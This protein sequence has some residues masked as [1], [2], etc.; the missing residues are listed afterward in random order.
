MEKDTE[1]RPEEADVTAST[2]LDQRRTELSSGDLIALGRATA[3]IGDNKKVCNDHGEAFVI[4]TTPEGGTQL[5]KIP[6]DR[7]PAEVAGSAR[8]QDIAGFC[9]Y[10]GRFKGPGSYIFRSE[11]G[12]YTCEL[13]G[14]I[15]PDDPGHFLHEATLEP[16][17]TDQFNE[18][19]KYSERCDPKRTQ[20]W[21]A[22][23]MED[24]AEDL[25]GD[26]TASDISDY[27]LNF[28]K[29]RVENIN[30][31]AETDSDDRSVDFS[32]RSNVKE[33][34]FEICIPIFEGL[35][36]KYRIK[37]V[38]KHKVDDGKLLM[39]YELK[40]A[41]RVEVLARRDIDTEIESATGIKPY[42]GTFIESE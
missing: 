1:E 32:D 19:L 33:L 16:V 15:T 10:V 26:E 27:I 12:N 17:K 13:D 11:V 36:T 22:E 14:H 20:R 29:E 42:L 3:D 37:T 6:D 28:R 31:Q 9:A 7:P 23:F 2:Q 40:R 35:A 39:W 38:I 34:K 21:L 24:N 5:T 30:A 41:D 4:T 25:Y 8:F 18:W